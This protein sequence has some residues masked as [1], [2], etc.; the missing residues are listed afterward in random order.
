MTAW[1]VRGGRSGEFEEEALEKGL[2]IPGFGLAAELTGRL[3]WGDV[4]Y[5]LQEEGPD[6]YKGTIIKWANEIWNFRHKIQIGDL[7]VMPRKRPQT[8]IVGKIAGEYEYSPEAPRGCSHVR[9]VEWIDIDR[10]VLR[11]GVSDELERLLNKRMTVYDISGHLEE[12]EGLWD[13]LRPSC[14]A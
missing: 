12:I 3:T 6:E 14:A 11:S 1:V 5:L 10:G 2:L 4:R 8:I 9:K 7:V 13:R